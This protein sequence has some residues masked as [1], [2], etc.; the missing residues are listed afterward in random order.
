MIPDLISIASTLRG[1]GFTP[2]Q[3]RTRN[4]IV[5]ASSRRIAHHTRALC[6]GVCSHHIFRLP[7]GGS[8]ATV[9]RRGRSTHPD[10][11][12]LRGAQNVARSFAAADVGS[13]CVKDPLTS[14]AGSVEAGCQ[15]SGQS[16]AGLFGVPSGL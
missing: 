12:E 8:K 5:D 15:L 14:T 6:H 13:T 11:P 4:A 3:H 16:H 2:G 1:A 7:R 9:E 10:G